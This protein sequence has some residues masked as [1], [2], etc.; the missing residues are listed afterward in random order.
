MFRTL[1]YF[2]DLIIIKVLVMVIKK[3]SGYIFFIL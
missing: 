1:K 3:I 2:E